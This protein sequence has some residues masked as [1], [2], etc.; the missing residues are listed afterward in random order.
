MI[1]F[2]QKKKKKKERKKH[3]SEKIRRPPK[4]RLKELQKLIRRIQALNTP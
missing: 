1:H 2:S 4:A 3:S